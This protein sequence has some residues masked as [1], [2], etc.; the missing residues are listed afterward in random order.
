M[1]AACTYDVTVQ[2]LTGGQALT[3][4]V[5]ATYTTEIYV[6]RVGWPASSAVQAI[7][8]NGNNTPLLD[9]LAG[10]SYVFDSRPAGDGPL[11]PVSDPGGAG[12]PNATSTTITADYDVNFLS[13]IATLI[14]TNDGLTGL[15]TV[16]LP[17]AGSEVYLTAG[18]DAGTGAS[19]G[20]LRYPRCRVAKERTIGRLTE[21]RVGRAPSS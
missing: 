9:T 19:H 2:N 4:P 1:E 13:L 18:Y 15:N 3:P 12:H 5:V 21:W 17:A 16:R 8:E 7:A 11:V 14:C 20:E 10:A 6:S